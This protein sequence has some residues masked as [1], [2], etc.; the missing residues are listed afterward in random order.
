MGQKLFQL[1][2]E[3]HT[4]G[5]V[6]IKADE[7]PW[8]QTELDLI[9]EKTSPKNIT[10]TRNEY[11]D[12]GEKNPVSYF[13]LLHPTIPE[14][15]LPECLS[16]IRNDKTKKF[17]L[18]LTGL[19][20]FTIDRCQAHFYQKGDFIALHNDSKSCPEYLYTVILLLN[21]D[22]V[23]GEFVMIQGS[24]TYTLKPEKFSLIV[25]NSSFSHEVKEINEGVRHAFVFFLRKSENEIAPHH[26]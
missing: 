14:I 19:S 15:H 12:T 5:K 9:K 13:R 25:A 6:V 11:G 26:I 17:L 8:N 23:G 7:L 24:H 16:L 2:E 18:S 4:S 3:L 10:Y 22:Y 21:D 1:I 20:D